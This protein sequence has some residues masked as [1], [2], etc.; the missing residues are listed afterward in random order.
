L[1]TTL[2]RPPPSLSCLPSLPSFSLL[3]DPLLAT[4]FGTA[5]FGF[6]GDSEYSG[7]SGTRRVFVEDE[8]VR[9]GEDKGPPDLVRGEA[10]AE[11]VDL[12]RG[13]GGREREREREEGEGEGEG[14][15]DWR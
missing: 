10:E 15:R 3:L 9:R 7:N 11:V 2:A 12:V 1:I 5:E 13:E 8:L 6:P 14:E 4:S